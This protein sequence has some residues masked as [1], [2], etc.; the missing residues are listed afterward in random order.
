[1]PLIDIL[2]A[3]HNSEGRIGK[4]LVSLER[5]L[6]ASAHK[7]NVRVVLINNASTDGT[8]A[9]AKGFQ[10][11]LKLE[12]LDAP[13]AGKSRALN[14]AVEGHLQGELVFFTDDDT[15]FAADWLDK[16]VAT[17]AVQ[18][19]YDIFAG[20][21]IGAWEKEVDQDLAS[22]IPMSSTYAVHAREDSGPCEPGL[23]WGPNMAVRR[24]VFDA[25]LRFNP[26][27]GP[28][29]GALYPM[30]QDTEFATRA[31]DAGFKSYFVAEAVVT[32]TIK[33]ATANEDWVIRRAERLGYGIFAVR[34]VDTYRREMPDFIPLG[35]EIGLNSLIW[36]AA[37]PLTFLLPRSKQR[38]WCRWRKYYY[39][40][41]KAGY[42]RF[43][44]AA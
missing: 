6:A 35:L 5:M 32:H 43:V 7:D 19:D 44:E 40:G 4:T 13:E 31:H 33:A 16:F 25:G 42:R 30:G 11:R 15:E 10:G 20:R 1:M 27:V 9:A 12:I 36:N 17:I 21:I 26:A 24:K 29:P 34:K 8:A 39:Q 22:W 41:L 18:P 14:L 28:Q 23:V 3:T 37:Y 2:I 38:F